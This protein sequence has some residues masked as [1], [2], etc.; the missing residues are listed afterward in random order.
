MRTR[1]VVMT[2]AGSDSGGGAGIQ[3]DLKTFNTL[4]VLGV[5]IVTGLTAQNTFEVTKVLEVP[6]EFIEAQFDTVMKDL[7]PKF[8][9]TGMLASKKVISVVKKKVEE[10]KINLVLDPVMIAKSGA[11]LTTEDIVLDLIDLSKRSILI[12]PNRFE[13]EKLSS[14]KINN[15]DDLKR[16][17]KQ[18]YNSLSTNV[19]IKGGEAF[20]GK[21]FA[22][23]EGEEIEL[24]GK[25]IE[26]KN[27]HGSGDTF[28]ASIAG[29]LAL[30]N[31]LKD[32]IIKAKKFTDIAIEYSLDLG[33]GHGP[34]DPFANA[35]IQI[36]K[37]KAR[38]DLEEILYYIEKENN[39]IKQLIDENDKSNIGYLTSY[40][41]FA[42]LAGGIIRYL[43][44][45]KID[46]PILVNWKNDG[47]ILEALKK[48]NKK[49][50]F[51]ISPTKKVIE[52]LEKSKIRISESGID[53][54]AMS[55]HGKIVI[56]ANSVDEMKKKLEEL[57]E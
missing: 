47:T 27:T 51:L 14:S 4:G 42:T 46:G 48:S 43:D 6:P 36:E 10:Y 7:S 33:K 50:G 3:A 34:V 26:T 45:L 52:A 30:G 54:D 12:T 23:I 17:A 8:A 29:Y 9:K 35:E 2:I 32:A 49:I 22:I 53:C 40:G 44:W 16:V 21:D 18:L 31:S 1:P 41:D 25:R 38:E 13:A 19:V 28:S 24:E 57:L 39:G 37:E 11:S 5:T 56:L 15:F 55:I 20:N